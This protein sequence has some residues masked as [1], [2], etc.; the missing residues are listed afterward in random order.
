MAD[1]KND[2]NTKSRLEHEE[3]LKKSTN[4]RNPTSAQTILNWH[5]VT[6]DSRI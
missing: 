6:A 5:N 4:F 3:H 1:Q 2:Q